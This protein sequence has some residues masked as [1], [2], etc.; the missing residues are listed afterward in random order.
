MLTILLCILFLC[1]GLLAGT[2]L[3]QL[4]YED[5]I[6]QTTEILE[7]SGLLNR[8]IK[9]QNDKICDLKGNVRKLCDEN[10]ELNRN[11]RRLK[12]KKDNQRNRLKQYEKQVKD[13][14]EANKKLKKE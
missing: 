6:R 10:A 7:H 3:K 4:E 9:E 12:Q 14:K 11:N 5:L 2:Y 1:V 13:L 8:V